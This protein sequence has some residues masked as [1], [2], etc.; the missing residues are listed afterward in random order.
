MSKPLLTIRV[1]AIEAFRAWINADEFDE[2]PWV[3]EANVTQT[4]QGVESY[5][6]K[7]AYGT[8]GHSIIE[9]APRYWINS[10]YAV[11]DFIFTEAQVNPL[12]KF[13][14]EHP[15]MTRETSL[16]KLYHTRHFD[17]I[18]TGTCDHLEGNIMRDTKFKFSSFDVADFMDSLQ[19]RLY[20]HMAGMQLFFFD[21]FSVTGFNGMEDVA[22]SVI[23]RCDSMPVTAYP[24]MED[25]IQTVLEEFADFIV[26]KN[27]EPY[28]V[29]T[30]EKYKRIIRGDVNLKKIISL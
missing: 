13:R 9:D 3:N 26:F 23:G 8:A 16:S 19:W 24:G 25:D 20:L 27:L 17:L 28:L 29:I 30:K 5:S 22:K 4:I 7:A 18:I 10:G 2:K 15:W 1:T 6:V 21:F 12:L 11:D 14:S